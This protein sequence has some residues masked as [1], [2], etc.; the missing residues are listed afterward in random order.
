VAAAAAA[1]L[2]V[3]LVAGRSVH[4]IPSLHV[5]MRFDHA[6]R[7]LPRAAARVERPLGDEELLRE[8]EDAVGS[9]GPSA[10]RSIED[11]TPVAW[12]GE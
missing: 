11:V 8:I 1:G 6:P 7:H 2:V 10:L 4:D 9:A 12:D 3:G 5:P